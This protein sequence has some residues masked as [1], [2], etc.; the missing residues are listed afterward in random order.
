MTK[1]IIVSSVAAAAMVST[2]T[3]GSI[4]V[5]VANNAS[6]KVP[7]ELLFKPAM[8]DVE[9]DFTDFLN[10]ATYVAELTTADRTDPVFGTITKVPGLTQ[11]DSSFTLRVTDGVNPDKVADLE[12]PNDVPLLICDEGSGLSVAQYVPTTNGQIIFESTDVAP[13][14]DTRDYVF[15]MGDC[16]TPIDPDEVLLTNIDPCTTQLEFDL[17]VYDASNGNLVDVARTDITI[18]HAPEYHL[19][20]T[21]KTFADIGLFE[22]IDIADDGSI[23]DA[24]DLTGFQP[25]EAIEHDYE[26]FGPLY[27]AYPHTL[28][29][30]TGDARNFMYSYY[31]DLMAYP[32]AADPIAWWAVVGY[33][34]DYRIQDAG[35]VDV[36]V[37]VM[38]NTQHFGGL[39]KEG[40]Y[41]DPAN[42]DVF[43]WYSDAGLIPSA[44]CDERYGYFTCTTTGVFFDTTDEERE[45]VG[46]AFV[47]GLQASAN[48]IYPQEF[49]STVEVTGGLLGTDVAQVWPTPTYDISTCSV[50]EPDAADVGYWQ[51]NGDHVVI[52][53]VSAASTNPAVIKIYN[54]NIQDFDDRYDTYIWDSEVGYDDQSNISRA[55]DVIFRLTDD[56]GNKAM[57]TGYSIPADQAR[58]YQATTLLA[59]A[60]AINPDFGANKPKFKAEVFVNNAPKNVHFLVIQLNDKG[61]RT[62]PVYK[63]QAY[64]N[65]GVN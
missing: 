43:S 57:V 6:Y 34:F 1:K 13:V 37:N 62:V 41:D 52:P 39:I 4:D 16:V 30:T 12:V 3:A 42:Y 58:A 2:V 15:R 7:S 45:Y 46:V 54:G 60:Q 38:G 14:T 48:E 20:L 55:A 10:D 53:G 18:D 19:T 33:D 31:D 44:D 61:D 64:Y 32:Q 51:W 11:N 40:L 35:G 47:G 22:Q 5:T 9:L 8:N 28:G 50:V 24:T 17:L 65:N 63:T 29:D 26:D 56:E 23:A 25:D 59:D 49:L 36:I 27:Y 21:G